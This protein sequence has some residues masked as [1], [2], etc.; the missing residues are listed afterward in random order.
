MYN[1]FILDTCYYKEWNFSG[2]NLYDIKG[3]SSMSQC[4][5]KCL[6]DLR[7]KTFTYDTQDKRCWLKDGWENRH[8]GNK[9]VSSW[10]SCKLFH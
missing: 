10:Q 2:A 6:G 3:I 1:F 8:A 4:Q 9:Y 5:S 7:C